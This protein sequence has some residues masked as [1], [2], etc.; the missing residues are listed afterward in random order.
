MREFDYSAVNNRELLSMASGRNVEP[1]VEEEICKRT[2]MYDKW[3]AAD[4]KRHPFLQAV[5]MLR[6][7]ETKSNPAIAELLNDFPKEVV[8]S[9]PQA[10]FDAIV[11]SITSAQ[12][13]HSSQD[14]ISVYMISPA[15]FSK[16]NSLYVKV[17][18][19]F[20]GQRCRLHNNYGTGVDNESRVQ[21]FTKQAVFCGEQTNA[22]K[23]VIRQCSSVSINT[24]EDGGVVLEFWAPRG[25]ND[26]ENR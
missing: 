16:T 5:E 4:D 26:N 3:L 21:V 25:G 15:I 17:K 2:I 20:D 22:L 7:E 10:D 13:S 1:E 19:L 11:H 14:D 24:H 9:I 8:D 18:T 23:E 12:K 6:A